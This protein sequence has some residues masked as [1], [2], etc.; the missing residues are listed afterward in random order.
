MLSLQGTSDGSYYMVCLYYG[1]HVYSMRYVYTL[2]LLVLLYVVEVNLKLCQ[3]CNTTISKLI[4]F[5]YSSADHL[6]QCMAATAEVL[7]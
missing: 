1:E 6:L 7:N 4:K 5:R 2:L 3:K